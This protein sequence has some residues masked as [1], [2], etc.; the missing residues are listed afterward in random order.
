MTTW[1]YEEIRG[2]GN[3]LCAVMFDS[4]PGAKILCKYLI[5]CRTS[6]LIY[7][8]LICQTGGNVK[9]S[10][11]GFG[12][13]HL[14]MHSQDWNGS[15]VSEYPEVPSLKLLETTALKLLN[16]NETT[17]FDKATQTWTWKH[18]IICLG[19]RCALRMCLHGTHLAGMNQPCLELNLIKSL[20]LVWC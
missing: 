15:W 13:R 19:G 7:S 14:L 6:S 4:K 9:R 12:V 18:Q 1:I 20:W 10:I 8:S 5:M 3:L 16:H 2:T 17:Y 11:L